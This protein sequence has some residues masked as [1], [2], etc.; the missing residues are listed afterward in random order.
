MTRYLLCPT[1]RTAWIAPVAASCCGVEPIDCRP[2]TY[3]ALVWLRHRL[4]PARWR[5]IAAVKNRTTAEHWQSITRRAEA[6]GRWV[7]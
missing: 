7:A 1:C 2:G 5:A 6:E 4:T 3:D